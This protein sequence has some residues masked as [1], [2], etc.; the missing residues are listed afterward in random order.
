MKEKKV[1]N[2]IAL[3]RPILV[4]LLVFYHAFAPYSGG[5]EPI[6]GFPDVPAYWW[7]DKLSYAFMLEL[8]VFVSGY[9]FGFQVRTKGESK[10]EAKSLFSNKT[11]RLL[12][13]S[14]VFS[15]LYVILIRGVDKQ[16]V[17]QTIYDV[18]A[19]AGHLWFLPMLFWCFVLMWVIEKLRLRPRVVIPVLLIMSMLP[20]IPVPFHFGHTL[21][22]MLFFYVGYLIQRNEIKYEKFY[23]RR[24]TTTT[25][26]LF[27]VS[28]ISLT[29]L[30]EWGITEMGGASLLYKVMKITIIN[31]S[32]VIYSSLGI[33]MMFSI[34]GRVERNR[35]TSLP[36][37]TIEVGSLSMGVY[38]FQQFILKIIYDKT[39]C[40]DLFGVYFLPWFGFATAF[41]GS[42]LLSWVLRKTKVGRA[43]IG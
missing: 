30:Q 27:V 5:W 11:K 4:F 35:M 32:K 37:W 2:N 3:I 39:P 43:L 41:I 7:M 9:V 13:P 15:L 28:F 16:P 40:P 24:A 18:I 6:D 36:R 14:M 31:V 17:S 42:V 22:Y 12:I 34:I 19:G 21:Y 1:L 33:A 23:T 10:L 8:F 38:I 29:L 25:V 20:Q 26:V